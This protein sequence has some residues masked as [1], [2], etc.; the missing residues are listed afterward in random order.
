M[1]HLR[2]PSAGSADASIDSFF[3]PDLCAPQAVFFAVLLAELVVLLHVLALGPLAAF[4]WRPLSCVTPI[5]S[6]GWHRSSE[7]SCNC[8]S[9]RCV[10][11]SDPIFSSI[12]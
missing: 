6:S 1:Q 11:A 8:V 4:D 2:P 7:A 9:M 10:H 12:R 3:I 5:Y